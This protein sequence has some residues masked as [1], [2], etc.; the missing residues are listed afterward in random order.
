M[1]RQT[2]RFLLAGLLTALLISSSARAGYDPTI[3][4]WLSRDPMNNAELSQGANLY[5]YVTNDPINA[6]DPRGLDVIRFSDPITAPNGLGLHVSTQIGG[7]F[8]TEPFGVVGLTP[9]SVT[10]SGVFGGPAVTLNPDDLDA[11]SPNINFRIYKTTPD[12]DARLWSWFLDQQYNTYFLGL[13]DCHSM[14]SDI[15]NEMI[16]LM[17]LGGYSSVPY[18]DGYRRNGN[19]PVFTGASSIFTQ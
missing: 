12:V 11:T 2:A 3:G 5:S 7:R 8:G 15:E 6:I 14:A 16:K 4:R 19:S 1:N 13:S 10:L 9:R 18:I 17:S